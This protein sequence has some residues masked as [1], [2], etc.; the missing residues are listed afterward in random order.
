MLL[1]LYDNFCEPHTK[2]KMLH[3][4]LF[5]FLIQIVIR[6]CSRLSSFFFI[7]PFFC[8]NLVRVPWHMM[9]D[10]Y[11]VLGECLTKTFIIVIS[12]MEASSEISLG[13]CKFWQS[14]LSARS[15]LNILV[16]IWEYLQYGTLL[17]ANNGLQVL[18]WHMTGIWSDKRYSHG[19]GWPGWLANNYIIRL[20]T[21][22]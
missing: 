19:H 9:T 8:S 2:H 17:S 18:R 1:N 22:T 12:Y 4:E 7:L 3:R 20:A 16:L 15:L 11:S 14:M 21:N 10:N 6:S 5:W 13:T